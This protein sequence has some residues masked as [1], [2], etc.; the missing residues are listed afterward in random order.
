MP[1][2]AGGERGHGLIRAVADPDTSLLTIPVS[3]PI[4]T[5]HRA[6]LRARRRQ[7]RRYEHAA[8]GNLV[9]MPARSSPARS[10]PSRTH[11]CSAPSSTAG[12]NTEHRHSGIA[13][14]TPF[15]VHY[16][17]AAAVQDQ[18]AC[19]LTSAYTARPERFVRHPPVPLA[20]PETA[21]INPPPKETTNSTN[22][23]DQ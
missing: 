1:E 8:P 5:I 18:R 13:M 16:G 21:W 7:V 15:D 20:V 22:Q 3:G 6:P 4:A 17:R 14:H 11:A 10:A 23:P 9:P 19:V 2:S 12:H